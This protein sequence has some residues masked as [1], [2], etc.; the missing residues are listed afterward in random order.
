MN[1]LMQRARSMGIKVMRGTDCGNYS[2]M[3]YGKMHAKEP[4]ILVRYGGYSQSLHQGKCLRC[5][6]GKPARRAGSR[7]A[8]RRDRFKEKPG[9][10]YPSLP[11]LRQS[12]AGHQRR[13]ENKARGSGLRGNATRV[14]RGSRIGDSERRANLPLKAI[15]ARASCASHP[16]EESYRSWAAALRELHPPIYRTSNPPGRSRCSAHSR[17]DRRRILDSRW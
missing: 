4:E 7:Q 12:F 10:G 16:T 9:G 11:R 3:P 15:V 2:W 17:Q 1:Q 5:R 8:R 14:P 6:T 13:Q